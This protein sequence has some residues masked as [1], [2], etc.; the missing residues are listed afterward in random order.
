MKPLHGSVREIVLISTL[1]ILI[2]VGKL[3]LAS[4]PNIEVVSFLFITYA[5]VVGFK[6]TM[7]ISIVFTTT[8][9]LIWGFGIWTFGYYM[10]WP[11]LVVI[12]SVLDTKIKRTIGWAIVSGLF[13]LSFGL[14]FAIYSAPLTGVNV[15]AYWMS[16]ISFDVIHM[17]GNFVVM[18]VLFNPIKSVLERQIQK[19]NINKI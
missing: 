12:A 1:S 13:G 6:R 18:L 5:V 10:F 8:E 17:I 4:I 14:L 11:L 7:L 3:T 15:F 19:W 2:T 16:G 9:I